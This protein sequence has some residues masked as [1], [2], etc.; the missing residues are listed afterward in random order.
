MGLQGPKALPRALR[1]PPSPP[2]AVR[3]AEDPQPAAR[4]T[5]TRTGHGDGG[6]GGRSE[7]LLLLQRALPSM[8]ES[9]PSLAAV[10]GRVMYVRTFRLTRYRTDAACAASSDR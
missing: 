3:G 5:Q 7:A 8:K 10:P 1:G 2:V 6:V 9:L 4:R